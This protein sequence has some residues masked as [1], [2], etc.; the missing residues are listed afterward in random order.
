MGKVLL[1]IAP[2]N[3]QDKEFSVP[4]KIIEE[5]GHQIEV[6]AKYK[7]EA[8][9]QQGTTCQVEKSL[10]E[11]AV[12]GYDGV[13]LVGGAGAVTYFEDQNVHQIVRYANDCNKAIGAINIAPSI[14]ANA[15]ILSGRR[16]S[17][18]PSQEENLREKGAELMSSDVTLDGKIVT[19][20]GPYAVEEFAYKFVEAL[21]R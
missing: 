14:L 18:F 12:D 5:A 6:A 17:V 16:A 8:R 21:K 3:F 10:M 13:L 1:I 9:G 2:E 4:K 7:G 15:G 20:S 11:I 19:A